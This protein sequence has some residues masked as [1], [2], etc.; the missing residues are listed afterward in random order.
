MENR[1]P[2]CESYGWEESFTGVR[3]EIRLNVLDDSMWR[4]GLPG[5]LYKES[6]WM[7]EGV[8]RLGSPWSA[9]VFGVLFAVRASKLFDAE[10]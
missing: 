10:R 7:T 2:E 5:K 1:F 9:N 8:G 3:E 6:A 4:H